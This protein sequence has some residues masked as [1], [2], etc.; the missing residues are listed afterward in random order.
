MEEK[1][2][3]KILKEGKGIMITTIVF[4]V[5]TLGLFG[6]SF[7]IRYNE[8][9]NPQ[10]L[11]EISEEEGI[12]AKI[13]VTYGPYGFAQDQ[14]DSW[15]YFV[16]DQDNVMYIVKITDETYEYMS[17]LYE[18]GAKEK[19]EYELKGYTF[20][21]SSKLKKVAIEAVNEMYQNAEEKVTNSNFAEY[22]GYVYVDETEEPNNQ[23]INNLQGIGIIAG[24]FFIIFGVIFIVQ[25]VRSI[26]VTRN[27]ELME[28]LRNE[29][30]DLND[31]EYGKLKVYLTS[32][33]II[34]KTSGIEIIQYKD[35]IWEYSQIRYVNG[36]AQG[37]TL[38]VCTKDKKR[39][40][41]AIA[42]ANDARIDEIMVAIKDRN[43][44]VKIGFTKENREFFKNY[45]KEI[46]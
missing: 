32:K 9:R 5:I 36:T 18:D 24:M 35:V 37:K 40:S 4:L 1:Q 45:Q 34:S 10:N 43:E 7:Y 14:D 28:E 3:N 17:S 31:D 23:T 46:L 15:Y 22:L 16:W 27:K 20:D 26:K 38:I 8:M 42:G 25:K 6:A 41:V 13:N 33:Y 19:I 12:Y 39:H 30:A 29:L 44:N 2:I 11:A 21:I